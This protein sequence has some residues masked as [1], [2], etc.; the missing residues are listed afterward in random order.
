MLTFNFTQHIHVLLFPFLS[1]L[2]YSLQPTKLHPAS[3]PLY[4]QH[5]QP[6]TLFTPGKAQCR[7]EGDN[8][9]GSMSPKLCPITGDWHEQTFL[10]SR[11]QGVKILSPGP[12]FTSNQGGWVRRKKRLSCVE[13]RQETEEEALQT[14]IQ[15]LWRNKPRWLP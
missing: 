1:Q 8:G 13:R 6:R 15:N 10:C 12:P 4:I 11:L 2:C 5:P 7:T 14:G 3:G 9:L